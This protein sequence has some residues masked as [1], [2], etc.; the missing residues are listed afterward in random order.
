[1]HG[2]RILRHVLGGMNGYVAAVVGT[3]SAYVLYALYAGVHHICIST[4]GII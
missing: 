4:L 1:M 2:A 3:D